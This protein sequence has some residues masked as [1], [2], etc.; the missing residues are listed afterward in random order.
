MR[1]IELYSQAKKHRVVVGILLLYGALI[2][3]SIMG[4]AHRVFDASLPGLSSIQLVDFFR[5]EIFGGLGLALLVLTLL[6][7][8]SR[9]ILPFIIGYLIWLVVSLLEM[10]GI[11]YY[12]S[13]KDTNIDLPIIAY[14]IKNIEDLWP[15]FM[16]EVQSA[17]KAVV[18]LLLLVLFVSIFLKA[19]A[20]HKCIWLQEQKGRLFLLPVA[21]IFCLAISLIPSAYSK[22]TGLTQTFS[23]NILS[24]I[25]Y[26]FDDDNIVVSSEK[27]ASFPYQTQLSPHTVDEEKKNVVVIIMEST[28]ASATTLYNPELKTTPYLV[29]L[30]K[31]SETFQ[32]AY[33]VVPHTS[34]AITGILCGI[35]PSLIQDIVESS[36]VDAIPADCLPKVLAPLGYKSAFFQTATA[37]FENRHGL[38]SNMGYQ[39]LFPGESIVDTAGYDRVNYFGLEDK[40]ILPLSEEWLDALD[41]SPFIAT[42]LTLTPHHNYMVPQAYQQFNFTDREGDYNRYLKSLRYQDDFLKVLIQQ[43][44]DKGLYDNTLFVIVGDHGEGFGEH[45]RMQHDTVIYNE[46]LHVPLLIHDPAR[47]VETLHAEAISLIDV[48]PTVLDR[49]GFSVNSDAYDGKVYEQRNGQAIF[50]HCWRMRGCMSIIK[51]RYKLIHH[52]D[53]NEDELFDLTLDPEET[54]NLAAQHPELV[55]GMLSEL[56]AWRNH[57]IQT[58][59]GYLIRLRASNL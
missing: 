8:S 23:F 21:S 15:V 45:G 25:S 26:M 54:N 22:D 7:F 29:E 44:K 5:P 6:T 28:R 32:H 41:G 10:I 20:E 46:G 59:R 55:Q 58:Y 53:S 19:R 56:R 11:S 49:I 17:E 18:P 34:K 47:K 50:S 37:T 40:A 31:Q 51:E 9:V 42:Y 52:F 13:T 57:N 38:V 14:S 2:L 12:T 16:V 39:S 33:T 35:T 24:S 30:A 43:Y 27:G 1:L 3:A 48:V 4:K 36:F